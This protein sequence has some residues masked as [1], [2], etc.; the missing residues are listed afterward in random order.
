MVPPS[1]ERQCC[2]RLPKLCCQRGALP[3]EATIPPDFLR[4]ASN[5]CTA[6]K[7]GGASLLINAAGNQAKVDVDVA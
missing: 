3:V 2:H 6:R 5:R 4:K 1:G 7:A